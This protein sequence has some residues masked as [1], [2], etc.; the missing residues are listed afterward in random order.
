[1][2]FDRW[3]GQSFGNKEFLE[4]AVN[5]LLNDDGLINIRAKD[6]SIAFLDPQKVSSQKTKWQFITIALPLLLLTLFGFVFNYIRK[7][8]YS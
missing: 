3:T 1:L 4:N 2:G 8:K 5:Y 7:H 6:V